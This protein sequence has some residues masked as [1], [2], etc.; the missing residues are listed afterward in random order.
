MADAGQ[1]SYL[2]LTIMLSPDNKHALTR[3]HYPRSNAYDPSWVFAN[4]MGPNALWLM[5]WLCDAIEL[6]PGMRVLDMGCGR[7]MSSVFLA[8]EFGVQVWAN[9]LWIAASENWERV[10]AAGVQE[11]VFPIHAE[12][13]QLP[14]A[15]DFFDVILSVDSYHYYGT[16]DLYLASITRFLKPGGLFGIVVPG[17]VREFDDDVVPEHLADFWD[18]RECF[19]FHTLEWWRRHLSASRILDLQVADMLEGGAREWAAFVAAQVAAGATTREW[20]AAEGEQVAVDD[21]QYLGFIR[22]AGQLAEKA[23]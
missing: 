19:S 8:R 11:F 20:T 17:L 12:A 7:A 1:G 22:A 21:G 9:D 16:D 2:A 13:H 14:Y 15:D 5:E 18:P 23:A 6:R 10:C 4:E 3:A